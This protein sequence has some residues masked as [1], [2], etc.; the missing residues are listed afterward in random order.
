V[1][2]A[3]ENS[4]SGYR[5][6]PAKDGKNTQTGVESLL[7]ELFKR[8][9]DE[10]PAYVRKKYY[11]KNPDREKGKT[12]PYWTDNRLGKAIQKIASRHPGASPNELVS[13][14]ADEMPNAYSG[15]KKRVLDGTIPSL[16]GFIKEALS[17]EKDRTEGHAGPIPSGNRKAAAVSSTDNRVWKTAAEKIQKAYRTGDCS[18]LEAEDIL[19][20]AALQE[21][22]DSVELAA[23]IAYAAESNPS[24]LDYALLLAKKTTPDRDSLKN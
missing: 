6:S 5:K 19:Y 2:L 11:A 20:A 13:L 23:A 15:L 1:R 18:R 21:K 4:F 12:Q 16:E 3:G 22:K 9:L 14:I 7:A 24:L 10:C 17:K 8:F